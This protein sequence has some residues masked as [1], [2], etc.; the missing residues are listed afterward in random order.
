M[1]ACPYCKYWDKALRGGLCSL[2]LHRALFGTVKPY[3]SQYQEK[4]RPVARPR[5]KC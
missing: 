3:C 4:A 5:G 1:K 2:F